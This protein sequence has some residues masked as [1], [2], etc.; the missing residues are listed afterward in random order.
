MQND[1]QIR[2]ANEEDTIRVLNLLKKTAQW[3]K[4][5][6]INQWQFLLA[7]G[8]DIEIENSIRNSETFGVWQGHE[9]IATFT[10]SPIQSEWDQHIFGI[11]ENGDSLYLHRLAILPDYIGNGIG[12]DILKWITKQIETDKAYLKLDCVAGNRKL[13]QFYIN[14]G[15]EY[16]GE[17]DSHS[18]YQMRL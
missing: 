1:L 4:D 17:T 9:M 13:N 10:L 15:F 5:N 16:L 7:G 18:K 8:D 6:E 12:T 2:K 14:N 3:L 11:D